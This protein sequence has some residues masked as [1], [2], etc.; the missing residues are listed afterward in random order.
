[1]DTTAPKMLESVAGHFTL[2]IEQILNHAAKFELKIFTY[3]RD[4]RQVTDPDDPGEHLSAALQNKLTIS[5]IEEITSIILDKSN[6][7]TYLQ[8]KLTNHLRSLDA[9]SRK[10]ANMDVEV[11]LGVDD[12]ARLYFQAKNGSSSL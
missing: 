12:S 3:D 2:S 1:M 8:K 11:L 9:D 5:D 6:M 10:E 4:D 7:S